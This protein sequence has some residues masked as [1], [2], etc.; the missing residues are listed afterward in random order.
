VQ[1]G[2]VDELHAAYLRNQK[3]LYRFCGFTGSDRR[4]TLLLRGSSGENSR[5]SIPNWLKPVRGR[6]AQGHVFDACLHRFRF[7]LCIYPC[8][9][10]ISNG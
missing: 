3:A 10:L 2:E 9:S 5:N 8:G 7:T 6:V 1:V 4:Q